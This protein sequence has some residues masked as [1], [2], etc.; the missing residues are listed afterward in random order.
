MSGRFR[1]LIPVLFLLIVAAG[2]VVRF[3]GLAI[4][5]N[6]PA[7]APESLLYRPFHLDEAV[8][9]RKLGKLLDQ[10]EYQYHP[11]DLHGPGLI[12]STLPLAWLRGEHSGATLSDFTLRA[13][14]ALYG[15]GLMVLLLAWRREMG[16]VPLLAA[17]AVLAISPI[18]VFYSR[19]YIMEV[20]MVFW[21]T[22][23]MVAGWR[24]SKAPGYAW[25]ILF[26]VAGGITHATKETGA[27]SFFTLGLTGALVLWRHG[28]Q[29]TA[30]AKHWRHLAASLGCGL[31][32]S[33]ALFSVGFREPQAIW[34]S[35]R[36]YFLYFERA[37]G[38]GHEQPW[39]HYFKLLAYNRQ[40]EGGP[41]WS[42]GL[43]LLFGAVGLIVAF[44][45]AV[46]RFG[47]PAWW[48]WM[49]AYT[50]LTAAI[51]SVIPY[52]TPWS[53]LCWVFT[54][55]LM[56]GLGLAYLIHFRGR[57]VVVSVLVGLLFLAGLANLGRQTENSLT[58]FRADY[59]NPFVYAHTPAKLI[60]LVRNVHD[61][62]A[63]SPK[64]KALSIA[65]CDQ[66]VGWP[67]PWYFRAF[68]NLGLARALPTDP[69]VVRA[70][71]VLIISPDYDEAL[72]SLTE[73]THVF[74]TLYG[75]RD[76]LKIYN[77]V[78]KELY[79]RFLDSR[80]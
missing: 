80:G 74:E 3:W 67:L 7:D 38:S 22:V 28:W 47:D 53:M 57:A 33:A 44:T 78:E 70:Q 19:Y 26:G 16:A 40:P 37:E 71:E 34:D 31:F 58:R 4:P 55:V 52:K 35:I 20:P 29:P 59:R 49:A 23:A 54:L 73:D 51:Y 66:D 27:I 14:P 61:M 24:Y 65:I 25:A 32:A 46:R 13:V 75:I 2:A 56:A 10:G 62:A 43:T 50:V 9:G 15:I 42:E 77:Y 11:E 68:P 63:V 64:G 60:D 45:P 6:H 30:G 72:M 12:Y 39:Y 18:L 76:D 21:I 8:Q 17:G 69:E 36:T 41:F 48:R 5:W 79:E 1:L